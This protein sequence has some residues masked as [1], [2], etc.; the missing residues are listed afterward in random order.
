MPTSKKKKRPAVEKT[1]LD[2]LLRSDARYRPHRPQV[3]S[4]STAAAARRSRGLQE[5]GGERGRRAAL[6]MRR[7]KTLDHFGPLR[8]PLLPGAAAIAVTCVRA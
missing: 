8:A 4:R 3:S 7:W 5:P 2:T 6:A 1:G